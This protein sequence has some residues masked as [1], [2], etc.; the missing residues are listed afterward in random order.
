MEGQ[1]VMINGDTVRYRTKSEI[2]NAWGEH[3]ALGL[4]RKLVPEPPDDHLCLANDLILMRLQPLASILLHLGQ[5]GVCHPR[6]DPRQLLNRGPA[7][8]G[9]VEIRVT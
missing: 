8:E 3:A 7:T 9:D 1:F 4:F 2:Q 6:A 5:A